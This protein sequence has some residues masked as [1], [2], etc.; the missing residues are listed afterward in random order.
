MINKDMCADRIITYRE[1]SKEEFQN[2]INS[3]NGKWFTTIL[4]PTDPYQEYYIKDDGGSYVDGIIA[5][6]SSYDG[7]QNSHYWMVQEITSCT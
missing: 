3:Y 2:F 4:F 1:V 5:K 6:I 7:V